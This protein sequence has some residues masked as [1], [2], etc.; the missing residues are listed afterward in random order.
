MTR[1]K[2][3]EQLK[4]IQEYSEECAIDNSGYADNVWKDDAEAVKEALRILDLFKKCVGH[5][6]AFEDDETENVL[7]S[8]GFT[9][10]DIKDWR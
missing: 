5:I 9:D 8:L 1:E 2:L 3:I 10:D 6:A 7:K 4:G